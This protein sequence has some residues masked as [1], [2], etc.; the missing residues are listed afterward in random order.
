MN[1][2]IGS[3][4]IILAALLVGSSA[5]LP[6]LTVTSPQS[7]ANYQLNA[8]IRTLQSCAASPSEYSGQACGNVNSQ[9]FVVV[10]DDGQ[11]SPTGDQ[12]CSF[13]PNNVSVNV[14]GFVQWRNIGSLNHTITSD[15]S[16]PSFSL[17][18]RPN[19]TLEQ[20]FSTAG[21]FKYHDSLYSWMNGTVV[22]GQP[23]APPPKIQVFTVSGPVGWTV[24]GLDGEKALLS[25]SHQLKLYNASASPQKLL[26]S[27]SG[28]VEDSIVLA[29]R[30]E[31]I[32]ISRI[33]LSVPYLYYYIYGNPYPIVYGG[34]SG[35][36]TGGSTFVGPPQT[37]LSIGPY[38]PYFYQPPKTFTAWWV[39][40]PLSLGATVQVQTLTGSVR[41]SESLNLGGSLGSRDAWI[42]GSQFSEQYS[43][44]PPPT[45]GPYPTYFVANQSIASAQQLDY[46]KQSDLLFKSSVSSD[47]FSQTS[48]VFPVG[49]ILNG[50][51]YYFG[52]FLPGTP[53]DEPV[54]VT[55]T[56]DTNL[57]ITLNLLSTN[58]NLGRDATPPSGQGTNNLL[59]GAMLPVVTATGIAA[60]AMVGGAVWLIR[61]SQKK[62]PVQLETLVPPS[63]QTPS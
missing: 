38:F 17:F 5:A 54:T 61:R 53:L 9:G 52:G 58:I 48:T 34:Q 55:R 46:G 59:Q 60:A 45:Q 33:L 11:C 37:G 41:G 36:P 32:D 49:S 39:N 4:A 63:P 19:W 8:T 18:L 7:S 30:E 12:K 13:S 21:T 44:S 3:F 56:Q 27:E 14:G 57:S 50:Y 26:F 2:A 40:G 29:T 24:Q 35:I 51:G 43:Q 25:I 20:S 6:V 1:L 23:A 42:V 28:V 22:V 15:Q 62:G 10:T 16:S 47:Q 31:S